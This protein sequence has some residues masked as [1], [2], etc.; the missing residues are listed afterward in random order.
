MIKSLTSLRG[1]FILF[2]FFHHC[3]GLYPGGGTMA[4]S[5]FFILGG[6]SMTLGYRDRLQM[7]DFSYKNFIIRRAVKF[8]PLHWLCLIASLP[9]ALRHI[10]FKSIGLLGINAALL[11]SWIPLK[12]VY[13]SYNAVSWYLADTMFFALLFPALCRMIMRAGKYGKIM[14]AVVVVMIYSAVALLLPV[15]MRHAVLYISPLMRLGDFIFGIYI[16]LAFIGLKG[17]SD[18]KRGDGIVVMQLFPLLLIALLVVE[19]CLLSDVVRLFAP[20]YWPLIGALLLTSSFLGASRGGQSWLD[21]KYLLCLGNMSFIIYMTH[22][23][24]LRYT[25]AVFVN[26]L[27]FE[28]DIVYIITTLLLTFAVSVC[29]DRYIL[30]PVTQWLT[31][32]IRQ[33]TTV[34]S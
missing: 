33:S 31:K 7:P 34:R 21:N 32:K 28:C 25:S 4:V 10:D 1:I 13:F 19:S 9:L 26:T 2:I 8:Y 16:A 11:Q 22:Q 18:Q 27:H 12:S 30:K 17:G 15:G 14:I 3:L 24:V 29:V 5:F 6:F 23:L 20:L